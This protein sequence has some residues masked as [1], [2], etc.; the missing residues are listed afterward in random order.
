[1]QQQVFI[2]DA[3]LG[4]WA[5]NVHSVYK[6]FNNS[7]AFEGCNSAVDL[8]TGE[9]NTSSDWLQMLCNYALE[10]GYAE[11]NI[12]AQCKVLYE[13]AIAAEA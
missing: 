2:N 8:T 11:Q 12:S 10:E 7:Y 3:A 9:V 13:A 1:M 5:L 6:E 4:Q